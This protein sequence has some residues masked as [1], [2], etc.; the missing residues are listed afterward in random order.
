MKPVNVAICDDEEY[1]VREVRRECERYVR[2]EDKIECYL[3]S[4]ALKSRLVEE[5]P[6]VDLFILDIDN[7]VFLC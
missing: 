7:E 5:K 2:T 1:V 3:S 4:D 6:A